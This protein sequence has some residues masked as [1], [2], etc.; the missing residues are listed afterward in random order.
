M[1]ARGSSTWP[2]TRCLEYLSK[3]FT[4]IYPSNPTRI[5]P[6]HSHKRKQNNAHK[7]KRFIIHIHIYFI[8]SHF[9]STFFWDGFVYERVG[10][11]D[12]I[13]KRAKLT[14]RMFHFLCPCNYTIKW[15]FSLIKSNKV[16]RKA[17]N[18]EL[19]QLINEHYAHITKHIV[20]IYMFLPFN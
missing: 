18:K 4:I 1:S 5:H 3:S 11:L 15:I 13:L 20:Y 10:W 17:T 2:I 8:I 7:N 12:W 16:K 6:I 19:S 14:N 9:R